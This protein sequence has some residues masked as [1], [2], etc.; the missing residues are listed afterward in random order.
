[1]SP[2]DILLTLLM[3][4]LSAWF[5]GIEIAFVSVNKLKIEL[6]AKQDD[7]R[8]GIISG[9]FKKTS[10][11]ITAILVGNNLALVIYGISFGHILD[12]LMVRFLHMEPEAYRSLLLQTFISTLVIL[13]FGEYLPKAFFRLSPDRK[14]LVSAYVMRFFYFLFSPVVMLINGMTHV[15]LKGILRMKYE[16]EE[17]VFSKKDLDHYIQETIGDGETAGV[18]Q[19]IDTEMFNNALEFNETRVREFMIPRT[20]I[21]AI[22]DT[23]TL[24]QLL[25]KFIETELSKIIIYSENLDKITGYVHHSSLFRNPS[26]ISEVLQ[27]VIMIP[28]SMPANFLLTEFNKN[29]STLAV[30]VDEFGGTEGMVTIEDLV[31]E[32]FGEIDD[33]HDD[34]S[35]D[36]LIE[37]QIS[38]DTFLF[39]AR[40]EVDDLNKEYNLHLPEGDYNTLSGLVMYFAEKIPDVNEKL[41]LEDYRITVTDASDNKI[42]TVMVKCLYEIEGKSAGT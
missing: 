23:S 4:I 30:V 15:L 26:S 7:R 6:K 5:S 1:M 9:F 14:L 25:E 42:N 20:E 24:D 3:L 34:V 37:K 32:V 10:R 22:P 2:T 38:A 18:A 21:Q 35:E 13:V 41:E 16:D 19:E 39:S 11:M 40:L 36:E 27:P 17:I 29:R 28:E 31:E 8:A 33:E 12:Y